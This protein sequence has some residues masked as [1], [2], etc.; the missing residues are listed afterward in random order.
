[1]LVDQLG[2]AE[3]HFVGEMNSTAVAFDG[4]ALDRDLSGDVALGILV[5][6]TFD[7]NA[8]IYA[9]DSGYGVGCIVDDHPVDIFERSEHLGARFGAEYR[10][11]RTFVD[12]AIR[13]YRDN[14]HI[15]ELSRSF[16]VANM[17]KM[18]QVKRA[19]GLNHDF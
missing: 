18:K 4:I 16:K 19:V 2:R 8:R 13:R 14:K 10:P 12:E 15:T 11:A 17:T 6:L 1:M 3:S 5:I 9:F 7:V